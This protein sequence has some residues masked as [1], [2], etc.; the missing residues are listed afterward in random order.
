MLN[1]LARAYA[2]TDQ[3]RYMTLEE[4]VLLSRTLADQ[5]SRDRFDP[6]L[7]VG[8][9]NGALLPA[10][11]IASSLQRPV[12]FLQVRRKGSR[13]KKRLA[14]YRWI[15]AIISLLYAIE[16]VRPAL[17]W[18][19][20]RFN[21]L[22]SAHKKEPSQPSQRR[23]SILIVDDAVETGQTLGAILE[24][25]SERAANVKIAVISWSD[26]YPHKRSEITPDYLI[27]KRIHHYPWSHNSPY[28]TEYLRWLENHQI[29]E[30]E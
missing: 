9:A 25:L 30:W 21:Q 24:Q 28:R 6:E 12:E 27:S 15:L 3:K 10:T 4:A 2:D 16:L 1:E 29:C 26:D 20:D 5:V 7:I 17:R 22:E 8:V 13:I 11:V 19:I 14:K 23:F 18:V